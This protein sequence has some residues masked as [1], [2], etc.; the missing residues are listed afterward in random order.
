MEKLKNEYEKIN[1]ILKSTQK[2]REAFLLVAITINEKSDN[3]TERKIVEKICRA[4]ASPISNI[5]NSSILDFGKK[6]ISF[7]RYEGDAGFGSSDPCICN[8]L[9]HASKEKVEEMINKFS[10]EKIKVHEIKVIWKTVE[11]VVSLE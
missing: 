9:E 2:Q 10:P 1:E 8:F 3:F 5:V 4:F 11:I 7:K 6:S